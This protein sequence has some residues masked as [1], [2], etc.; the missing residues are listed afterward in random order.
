MTGLTLGSRI[1][2]KKAHPCGAKVWTVVRTGAD[3]KVKCEGCGRVIML[4][5]DELKKRM[6][7]LID[8]EVI[9]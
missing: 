8:T 1:E 5:H 9:L 7:R 6:K 3:F 2:M 4:A